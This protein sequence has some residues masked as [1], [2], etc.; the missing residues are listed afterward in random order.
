MNVVGVDSYI[1]GVV[2]EEVPDDWPLEVVK[3]QAVAARSYALAQAGERSAILYAD[4]R[5]Q[6][7]GGVEAESDVGDKAVAAT[8]RQVLMFDGKV[9][10]TFFFSSSG[11]R[12]ADVEDVF[13]GGTP[14][15]Y[16]VSVPDPGR[17]VVSA[18][19]LGAGR[20]AGD[21]GIEAVPRPGTKDAP[22][23]SRLRQGEGDRRSRRS[24]ASGG[25]P[26]ST[27][28]RALDLRSTWVTI[29]V[30]VAVAA[31]RHGDCRSAAD[32]DG[33]GAA[34][35]GADRAPVEG[36]RRRLDGRPRG[37]PGRRPLVRDRRRP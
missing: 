11:G 27:V 32:A 35:E 25:V 22:H 13:S 19:S 15:P 37:R 23:G 21:A 18:P 12:T 17:Q 29:G 31:G 33:N 16:L 5:S 9:A 6:V 20:A 36:G 7:Y 2:S 8:K 1:R 26:S 3:A 4:T 34:G 10:T 28:R 24:R 14:I 30:L